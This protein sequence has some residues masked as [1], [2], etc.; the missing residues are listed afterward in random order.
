MLLKALVLTIIGHPTR[1][2][3]PPPTVKNFVDRI[4]TISN[5]LPYW[6]Q[7]G[8]I[9]VRPEIRS[10]SGRTVNFIDGSSDDVDI[11]VWAT[12]YEIKLPFFPEGIIQW[13]GKVPE[14]VKS[15]G[16]FRRT[17]LIC[18]SVGSLLRGVAVPLR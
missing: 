9:S 16:Y 17:W 18:F 14:R 3:L 10:F 7:H 4:P 12:G 15:V 2:G 6:L 13:L 8:R 1:Y 11:V 5:Q